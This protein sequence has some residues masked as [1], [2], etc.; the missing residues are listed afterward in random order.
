MHRICRMCLK[1]G[2]SIRHLGLSIMQEGCLESVEDEDRTCSRHF[3]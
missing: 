2:D 3:L 1:T